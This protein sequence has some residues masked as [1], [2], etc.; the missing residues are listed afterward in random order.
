MLGLTMLL[1]AMGESTGEIPRVMFA[2]DSITHGVDAASY[3]WG[4]HRLWADNGMKYEVVGVNQ[5]N[6]RGGVPAGTVYGGAVFNN[7]HSAISSERSYEIAGRVNQ[8]GRL[9]NSNIYDW[10]GL[11]S[12]YTGKYRLAMPQEKPDMMFLLIGTNDALGDN[13]KTGGFG[14]PANLRRVTEN[15]LGKGGDMD[16]IVSAMR[17]TNPEA[18]I[19]VLGPPCW[20]DE[21]KDNNA[22]A[23]F[24][25]MVE[26]NK[27]MKAWAEGKDVVYVD[28]N[29]SLY[30]YTRTDKPG[31]G[32]KEFFHPLDHLHP[33]AQGDLLIAGAVAEQMGWSGATAGLPRKSLGQRLVR[34][35]IAAEWKHLG[36]SNPPTFSFRFGA[37]LPSKERVR[38]GE[39]LLDLACGEGVLQVL[40][41]GIRWGDGR[42]LCS[43]KWSK[44]D[45]TIA[46]VSRKTEA[47]AEPGYYVWLGN[48]LIGEALPKCPGKGFAGVRVKGCRRVPKVM[49]GADARGAYAPGYR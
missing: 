48:R 4:L 43:G 38:K 15:M 37:E 34:L 12:S 17:E 14:N 40:D 13:A 24:A 36:R 46:Y 19:V 44:V 5:G 28:V 20:Y 42:M 18:S 23:D 11:D 22:A 21:M 32:V 10:L 31:V 30:D 29:E 47:G 8:S 26:L 16:V 3:R 7:R 6:W 2:G 41:S 49:I 1:P 25:A 9:G 27:S 39:V 45:L 35:P 33:S